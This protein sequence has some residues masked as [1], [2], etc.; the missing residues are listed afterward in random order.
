MSKIIKYKDPFFG[1]IELREVR[2]VFLGGWVHDQVIYYVID[3][4]RYKKR[5]L[6][7]GI[8]Y[9]DTDGTIKWLSKEQVEA[10][11]R[12]YDKITRLD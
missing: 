8:Y 2:K 4:E 11:S 12:I 9:K 7:P 5:G 3:T 1:E 6:D 10:I